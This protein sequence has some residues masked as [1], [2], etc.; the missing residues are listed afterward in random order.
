MSTLDLPRLH[1]LV[2]DR[3]RV[4]LVHSR[5]WH[6]DPE[7]LIPQALAAT[8]NLRQGSTFPGIHVYLYVED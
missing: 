2:T 4:W 7:S 8:M 3:R 1:A 5:P 6:T